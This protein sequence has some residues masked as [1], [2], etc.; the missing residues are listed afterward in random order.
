[1][2]VLLSIGLASL[3]DLQQQS[4][5]FLASADRRRH[6]CGAERPVRHDVRQP[7]LHTL[8]ASAESGFGPLVAAGALRPLLGGLSGMVVYVLLQSGM[9]PLD[10]SRTAP[11]GRTS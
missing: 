10:R 6:G 11:P 3:P 1:M 2:G 8:F 9:V 5:M 7:E 4:P